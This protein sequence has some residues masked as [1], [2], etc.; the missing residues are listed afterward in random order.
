MFLHILPLLAFVYP[1]IYEL[2]PFI[3]ASPHLAVYQTIPR[4]RLYQLFIDQEQWDRAKHADCPDL[5][6][7][8]LEPGYLSAMIHAFTYLHTRAPTLS[9]NMLLELHD[10]AIHNVTNQDGAPMKMGFRFGEGSQI[11][12]SL[13]LF[14][15]ITLD[16]K[17]ELFDKW[18]STE[19]NYTLETDPDKKQENLFRIFMHPPMRTTLLPTT[20]FLS[21]KPVL[22]MDL[23]PKGIDRL[24]SLYE[25]EL[26]HSNQPLRAIAR[27]VQNLEQIHPFYD[28]N[29]RT[30]AIL[31]LNKLLIDNN[32]NPCCLGNPNCVD[33][34][35]VEEIVLKIKEGQDHFRQLTLQ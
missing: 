4:S 28:G 24:I 15:T 29:I 5:F 31:L 22:R 17:Q 9:S 21:F 1:A 26:R 3:N 27:L 32:L 20:M 12:F 13:R 10:L 6:F 19:S 14:K 33:G 11:K 23:L 2:Q 16:G 8:Q 34:L 7:D 35:S 30:F 25:E 18:T